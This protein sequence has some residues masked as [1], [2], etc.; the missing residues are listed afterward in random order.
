M[1]IA[2]KDDIPKKD[3]RA[4]RKRNYKKPEDQ[5]IVRGPDT[6]PWD[7]IPY[8]RC[9]YIVVAYGIMRGHMRKEWFSIYDFY[10]FQEKR[11]IMKKLN[12]TFRQL[13]NCG[14]IEVR[15]V[16]Q[17]T[18]IQKLGNGQTRVFHTRREFRVTQRALKAI[19]TV[20]KLHKQKEE[21]NMRRYAQ[22][23]GTDGAAKRW[24]D[25]WN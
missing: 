13:L 22:I 17:R 10:M 15:K 12:E 7:Y 25:D 18:T 16:P 3:K 21:R 8:S 24:E 6:T 14:Y 20:A 4:K 1:I 2:G 5:K 19:A 11:F 9:P 23:Y